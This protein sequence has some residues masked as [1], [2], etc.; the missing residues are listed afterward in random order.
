M[1]EPFDVGDFMLDGDDEL[2][3]L[4]L[5]FEFCT[6]STHFLSSFQQG[7]KRLVSTKATRRSHTARTWS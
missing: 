5:L 1:V 2:S 4:L 3:L 7:T 6:R